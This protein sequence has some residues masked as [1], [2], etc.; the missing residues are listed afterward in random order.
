MCRV[1]LCVQLVRMDYTEVIID[2]RFHRH[3]I[4]KNGANSEYSSVPKDKIISVG[5]PQTSPRLHISCHSWPFFCWLLVHS[6]DSAAPCDQSLHQSLHVWSWAA[7]NGAFVLDSLFR[8]S[9]F[10]LCVLVCLSVRRIKQKIPGW[11]LITL[12]KMMNKPL[13]F[14]AHPGFFI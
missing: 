1:S 13:R 2:Q 7:L 8:R 14:G 4:G 9:Y 5:A 11:A 12:D 6:A 3:L 10:Q